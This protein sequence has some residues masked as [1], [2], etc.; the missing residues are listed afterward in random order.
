ML[1]AEV[2][3]IQLAKAKSVGI[4]FVI[5]EKSK[6]LLLSYEEVITI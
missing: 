4:A 6:Q 3:G 1:L 5:R 2:V